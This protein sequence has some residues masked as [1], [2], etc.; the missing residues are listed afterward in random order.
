MRFH[1]LKEILSGQLLTGAKHSFEYLSTDSRL[2]RVPAKTLFFAIRGA[3]R[4]G[5]DYINDAYEKGIRQFIIDRSVDIQ[6][7]PGADVFQVKSSVVALQEIAA[8]HRQAFQYPVIAIT[9]SN[10][11]TTVKEWLGTLLTQK[12]HVVKSPGSYNSQIGVPLSVWEMNIHHEIGIFEAGISTT[13]EMHQLA[14]V[15]RPDIGIFTNIGPAHDQGFENRKQKAIEKSALFGGCKQV[16]C[17]A[18]HKTVVQTLE[19]SNPSEIIRWSTQDQDA[20][21]YY[22][23]DSNHCLASFQC[24]TAKFILP[25][26]FQS[27]VENILHAITAAILLGLRQEEIQR[28]LDM[29]QPLDMRL[30]LKSGINQCQLVDDSYNNDLQGLSVALDFLRSQ[31]GNTSKTVI[32]SDFLQ[33]GETEQVLYQ[34]FDEM[35]VHSK[36]DRLI[37]V[38]AFIS[39]YSFAVPNQS[40]PDTDSLLKNLPEFYKETILIKGARNFEFEKVVAALEEKQHRTILEVNFQA[41][42]RNLNQY[43]SLIESNT[44]IM[45][46]VKAFGYGGGSRE[47]ANLLQFHN[48]DYLGVAYADEAIELRNAGIKLPIMIMNP[49]VSTFKTLE[50]YNLEPEIFN[51]AG[52]RE[53][54]SLQIEVPIHLKIES[55]MNRLGFREQ[56]LDELVSLVNSASKLKIASIFT[57]FSSADDP[58]EDQFTRKQ[59]DLFDRCYDKIAGAIGYQPIK[60]AVNSVGIIR[61]PKYHFDMVRLGI[62]LYGFDS[63]SQRLLDPISSLK[64][65]ISQIKQ[66]KKGESIG[67]SRSGKAQRDMELAVIPIGYADGY[68]R[69]FGNGQGKVNLHEQLVPTI[70]NI[71]MDMTMIDVTGQEA[72][73]G[74]LVEV[75]GH[76]PSIQDLAGW[77]ETIPYEIL[78]SISHRVK[79]VYISE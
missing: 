14:Q 23:I 46:M 27:S 66:V 4:D 12:R 52:L 62:G 47:I 20:D 36:I 11:K 53:L 22:Q 54:L 25:S 79:R 61:W 10:G 77:A 35:L 48:I 17:R 78:T 41:L 19:K 3:N 32:V 60:H 50:R 16:I 37:G 75:F 69:V 58:G 21:F 31:S 72:K 7:F 40:F 8:H 38:G 5:H 68:L 45:V 1:T 63:S 9:G 18:E 76:S 57:H 56:E 64:T 70:G 29:I 13:G 71:C 43:K 59:A 51:I 49:P 67:Y 34:K 74:D 6:S 65:H 33:T 2:V 73:E 24:K 30:T 42:I 28:G 44:R 39:K 55:G 26:A 15:I